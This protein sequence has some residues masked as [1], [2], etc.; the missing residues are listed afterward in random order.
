MRRRRDP[1]V[2]QQSSSGSSSDPEALSTHREGIVELHALLYSPAHCH[3]D[4]LRAGRRLLR[5]ETIHVTAKDGLMC[6]PLALTALAEL[7][8]EDFTIR[9][10]SRWFRDGTPR[11]SVS[12]VVGTLVSHPLLATKLLQPMEDALE[13]QAMDV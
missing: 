7:I 9:H 11:F 5:S 13:D 2:S 3:T 10:P 4:P 1:S 6:T 12:V 8:Q